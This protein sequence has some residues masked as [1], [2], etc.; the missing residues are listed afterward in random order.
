MRPTRRAL[1]KAVAGSLAT[2][3]VMGRNGHSRPNRAAFS[4]TGG[5]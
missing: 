3:A 1:V 2:F 5:I 4:S